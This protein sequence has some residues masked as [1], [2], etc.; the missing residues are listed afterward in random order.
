MVRSI[1]SSKIVIILLCCFA[2]II[3]TDESPT[4]STCPH[5]R[6]QKNQSITAL[7]LARG[8]S[9]GIPLKNLAELNG[10]TLLGRAIITLQEANIFKEIWV[11]TNSEVIM[12]E[13][14]KCK[15]FFECFLFSL[16]EIKSM[17]F[18]F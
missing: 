8:G 10:Q 9:K 12:T 6:L 11:S 3:I 16:S 1:L 5:S 17:F 15:K 18:K 4:F 14:Q 13:A 7:I 2:K